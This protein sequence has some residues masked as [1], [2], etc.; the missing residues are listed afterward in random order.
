MKYDTQ[1]THR[2]SWTQAAVSWT[3]ISKQFCKLSMK[4][5]A[6]DL[7]FLHNKCKVPLSNTVKVSMYILAR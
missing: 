2:H 1:Q 6:I 5:V 3:V 7:S 4:F